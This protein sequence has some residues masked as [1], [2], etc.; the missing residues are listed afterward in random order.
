MNSSRRHRRRPTRV[1]VARA[2][3]L[4]LVI[5]LT[6]SALAWNSARLAPRPEPR[7][8]LLVRRQREGWA[9][10]YRPAGRG[11]FAT[12]FFSPGF[13]VPIGDYTTFLTEVAS[14]GFLVIAVPHPAVADPAT[15]QL[16]DFVPLAERSV[17]EAMDRLSQDTLFAHV[18]TS[19]IA[20]AGHS[21]GG[22]AAALACSDPRFK[23]AVDLDGSLYGRVVH[24]GVACPFLLVERSL[25]RFDTVDTPVFHEE[26]SQGRLHEDSLIAHSSL[27]EWVTIDGLDHMSFTDSGLAF[28]S[29]N[30]VKEAAGLRMNAALSQRI[31][32]ALMLD[33]LAR[34]LDVKLEGRGMGSLPNSVHRV[35]RP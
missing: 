29:S 8:D 23:I 25:T 4:T 24:Q 11:P 32:A 26:R 27:V 6:T 34:R 13:G 20:V 33:F 17:A 16:Y 7:G 1:R 2:L 19:R 5:A 10:I 21:I 15:A 31:T 12:L 30:W 18:D 14:N 9:D 3:G 35:T 28:G 22:A